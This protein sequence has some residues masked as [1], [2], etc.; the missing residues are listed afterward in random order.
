[1]QTETRRSFL[2]LSMGGV[3]ALGT[4]AVGYAAYSILVPAPPPPTRIDFSDVAPGSFAE[5]TA[6]DR[7]AV[8]F[9]DA[10]SRFHAYML[11]CPHAGCPVVRHGETWVCTCDGSTFALNGEALTGPAI[12]PLHRVTVRFDGPVML[13]PPAIGAVVRA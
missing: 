9:R 1:M 4:G 5:I 8:V 7:K 12:Q 6:S 3:A 10:D 11:T 2:S 13:V